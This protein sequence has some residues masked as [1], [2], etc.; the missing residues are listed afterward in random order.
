M[1][2]KTEKEIIRSVLDQFPQDSLLTSFGKVYLKSVSLRALQQH[3]IANLG[4]FIQNRFEY[5]KASVKAGND[6]RIYSPS[7]SEKVHESQVLEIVCPDAPYLIET[8]ET[9]LT[10]KGYDIVKLYHPIIYTQLDSNRSVVSLENTKENTS[11]YSVIFVE[12]Q[13]K[14]GKKHTELLKKELATK[15]VALQRSFQDQDAIFSKLSE[16]QNK[17]KQLPNSSHVFHSEWVDLFDWLKNNNF[18]FFGYSEFELNSTQNKVTVKQKEESGLGIL[19]PDYVAIDGS[20]NAT[21][22][23]H[24][25]DFNQYRS[26]FL[27]DTLNFPSPIKQ[28]SNLMRLSLKI[29]SNSHTIE[30]TFLGL[31]RRS[32]LH[33]KNLDTPII[34]RKIQT[35]FEEKNMFENSYDYNQ[36]IRFFTVTPKFE[37]F[38]TPN[39]LLLQMA[40]D[41]LSITNPN[42]IYVFTREKVIPSRLFLM[43]VFPAHL[44]TTETIEKIITYMAKSIPH[45]SFEH[46]K[47]SG[48]QLSRLHFYF[49]QS[50]KQDWSPDCRK[51]EQELREKIKPWSEQVMEEITK[52]SP[53]TTAQRLKKKYLH[54]FPNAYRVMRTAKEAVRDID[55]LESIQGPNDILFCLVPFS[56]SDSVISQKASILIVYHKEKVD[57]TSIMPILQNLK[58]HVYDEVT[59]RI[60]PQTDTIG[61]IHSFRIAKQSLDRIDESQSRHNLVEALLAIFDGRTSNDSLNGLVLEAGLSYRAI[62]ILQTYRNYLTQVDSTYSHEKVSSVLL[63]HHDMARLLIDYFESK[64]SPTLAFSSLAKRKSNLKQLAKTFSEKLTAIQDIAEDFILRHL[65]LIMEHTL[66]T[67]YFIQKENN[68]AFISIKIDAEN[69]KLTTPA[70]YREIFVYDVEMEGCHIRFGPVSRGGLRWSDRLFDY[71]K[72]ILGL[73]NTQQTK[74]VVIVPVG[75]KGG[76][77]V[78]K[79]SPNRAEEAKTQYKIGRAHV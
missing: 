21:L 18:S 58:I 52:K 79:H 1:T 5:F 14:E 43:V 13:L 22:E 76:F 62:N 47:S 20:C 12:F 71:R 65:F 56:F 27:F 9:L 45:S 16:V 63:K 54:A 73:V 67:N 36:I 70:P 61:Y 42:E 26:L 17:V 3:S 38:R 69:L 25:T 48:E 2:Q 53:K 51:L 46:V 78:K 72:E 7:A 19:S 6:F 40:E 66:R 15:L 50:S 10:S 57:L 55:Y 59:S 75:S 31:M 8:I 74:N 64:F 29:P 49:T 77:V 24:V 44:E 68:D 23:K 32:T 41:L 33:V 4:T 60:G 11:L 30:H 28:Q 34:R 35:I 37:L 39:K